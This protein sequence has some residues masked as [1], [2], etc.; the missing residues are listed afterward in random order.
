MASKKEL[1]KDIDNQVFG[2]IS[3]SLLFMSLHPDQD[4]E[5]VSAVVHEA[6]TLRNNL[7]ERVNNFGQKDDPK[8]V[9]LH[10]KTIK[11]DLS[12]GMGKLCK[13]LSSLSSGKKKK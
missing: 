12:E 3:D 6:V 2:L 8:A 9:K 13:K 4:A 1:K 7:I 11:S 5:E 10:F